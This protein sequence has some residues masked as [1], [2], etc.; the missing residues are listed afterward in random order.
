KSDDGG[1]TWAA[2]A[3]LPPQAGNSVVADSQDDLNDSAA[4]IAF[5]GGTPNTIG[6]AWSD[7]A[8]LPAPTD[9]GFY[10]ATINADDDPTVDANW[11]KTKL[12]T[13]VSTNETADG[14]INI[15][16]TSDG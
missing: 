1:V 15:K 13:L 5:G 9:N 7:Q 16:T 12:P 6:I 11:T 14:H 2:G 4:V 8:L 3:Q 10:F